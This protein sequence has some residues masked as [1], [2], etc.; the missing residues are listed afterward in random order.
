M[1]ISLKII[2]NLAILIMGLPGYIIFAI[3]GDAIGGLAMLV[4]AL[5]AA[6]VLACGG[7]WILMVS[8]IIAWVIMMNFTYELARRVYFGLR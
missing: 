4:V 1:K 2:K 8:P 7:H 5:A 6:I 3:L